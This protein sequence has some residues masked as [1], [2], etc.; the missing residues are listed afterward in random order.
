MQEL[1]REPFRVYAISPLIFFKIRLLLV[2]PYSGLYFYK[3]K[4]NFYYIFAGDEIDI[5]PVMIILII[6][7]MLHD[8]D[9]NYD[10]EQEILACIVLTVGIDGKSRAA[11][12]VDIVYPF[13]L[14]LK[15]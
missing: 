4:P 13:L 12:L 1:L 6:I 11:S 3:L 5:F 7:I 2:F 14:K 9:M 15:N 8:D 10:A